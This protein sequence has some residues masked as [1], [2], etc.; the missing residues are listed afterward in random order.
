MQKG[1]T[2]IEL[3]IVIAIIGILAAIAMPA[4]QDYIAKSQAAEAL[5]LATGLKQ[6]IHA[7]RE[8]NRCTD[9]TDDSQIEGKY[10][11]AEI[12]EENSGGT[13]KCGVK[14]KFHNS[15]VSDRVAN[16]E[17]YLEV[18]DRGIVA[19][20]SSTTLEDKYLPTAVK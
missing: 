3:M 2:L 17:I 9:N 11:I 16:K 12:I 1:F 14:Y 7:N 20:M 10:G 8:R 4:Y 18:D 5:T 19:R 13:L 6:T 15:N